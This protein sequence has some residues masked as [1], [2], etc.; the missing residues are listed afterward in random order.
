M[1]Y[2]RFE[3]KIRS[4]IQR[5]A[6]VNTEVP[7]AIAGSRNTTSYDPLRPPRQLHTSDNVHMVI[8]YNWDNLL[9]IHD[10]PTSYISRRVSCANFFGVVIPFALSFGIMYSKP[11]PVNHESIYLI[12]EMKRAVNPSISAIMKV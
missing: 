3:E 2:H 9:E 1:H 11:K 4:F 10:A 7:Y 12:L 5:A 8:I 6:S